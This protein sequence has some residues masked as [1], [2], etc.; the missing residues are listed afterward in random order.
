MDLQIPLS[1][2]KGVGSA[3]A[4]RLEKLEL[5]TIKDLLYHFP[6]R[7]EDFSKVTNLA[8]TKIGDEVTLK[9]QIWS[10][11]NQYTK[12]RKII[13]RA[14]LNDGTNSVELIWFNQSWLTKSI[15]TGDTLQVSGKV[16]RQGSK[17]QVIS[18]KW[19]KILLKGQNIHTGRLVPIYPETFGVSSK[20]FRQKLNSIVPLALPSLVDPLPVQFKRN[21]LSLAEAIRCIHFP[22]TFE[23]VQKARTRLA[24]DELFEIQLFSQKTR[25]DWKTQKKSYPLDISEKDLQTFYRALPF[26]LTNGQKQALF[27][28]IEDIRQDQAMNRLLQGEVGSGKT[29]V[30]AAALFFAFKNG[31]KSLLMAPTEILAFQHFQ[32]L[33]KILTPLGVTVGLYTGSHKFTKDRNLDPHVIVGTH[34]LLSDK[35]DRTRVGLIVVDEQQRFGVEQRSVLRNAQS[36]G[37]LLPHFLTMTATPIPR[38]VALTLY[39]DLDVS[40]I[41]ELPKGRKAIRTYVVPAHKRADAYAFI[42]KKIVENKDQAV[43]ITPLIEESETLISAKAAKA[44]FERLQHEV[45]ADLRTGLLHG[46]LKPKEKEAV[47]QQFKNHQLDI[48]VSTSVVEVGVDVPNA[49]I[50][51]IEGAE[52]FGLAQLHQ[53]RGRVGRG[54][55]ESFC[56][57]FSEQDDP[58]VTTRLKNLEHTS[59]GMKLAEIDLKIRGSGQ[60]FGT[61]QSGR[62]DLKIANFSDL[63]LIEEAKLAAREMLQDDPFLDKYPCYKRKLASLQGRVMPD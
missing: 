16:S 54:E 47:L 52:R 42:H 34:A 21:K 15:F 32:T 29:V 27:E 31:Y 14:I 62:L 8:E 58:L 53:F 26:E 36:Q 2:L 9:G 20:W 22:K 35:L 17:L 63:G 10:I 5:F 57:L 43:I 1:Q 46:K 3:F 19:E 41:G 12:F 13:T 45:F 44:E 49:T 18:P 40:I 51:V 60:L 6:F 11:Q 28:I 7:Y 4:K 24:F 50:I 59:D 23:D 61:Q 56:L 30:A 37:E 33:D 55:K 48:L 39:G 25:Y 38:T